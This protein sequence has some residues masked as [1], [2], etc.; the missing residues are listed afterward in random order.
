MSAY[1][2]SIDSN[3]LVG[4]G[5]E[6]FI[7]GGSSDYPYQGN[8]IGIDFAANLAISSIDFG[9]FHVSNI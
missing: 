3:H 5:D 8:S 6:G 2:K 1:I 7:N 4:I 9:T